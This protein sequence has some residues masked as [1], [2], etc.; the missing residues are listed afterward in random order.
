MELLGAIFV[1]FMLGTISLILFLG[2][3]NLSL[4]GRVRDL[5][6]EL[7]DSKEEKWKCHLIMQ[8]Y[9]FA[10]RY[11]IGNTALILAIAAVALFGL[12]IAVALVTRWDWTMNIFADGPLFLCVFGGFA[13][14][15][16]TILSVQESCMAR[17]SLFTHIAV[18]I[19][20]SK[21]KKADGDDMDYLNDIIKSMRFTG[22]DRHW[23]RK[24]DEIM[25][26]S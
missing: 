18:C 25:T 15:G 6:K 20:E 5:A 16:A 4:A 9:F 17:K 21:P 1:P 3:R 23:R 26:S 14:T 10:H 19:V 24:L 22:V 8:I 7:K 13:A 11:K 12:M 2:T